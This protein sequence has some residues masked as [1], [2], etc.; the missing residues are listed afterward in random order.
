LLEDGMGASGITDGA[1][2]N[3]IGVD[4]GLMP[5]MDNGGPTRTKALMCGSVAI[6]SG[7][8]A[9]AAN[10]QRDLPV[11]GGQRDMG[12][13]ELQI[14]CDELCE[15]FSVDV[16]WGCVAMDNGWATITAINGATEPLYIEWSTGET[17]LGITDLLDGEYWVIVKDANG[18]TVKIDFTIDCSTV[19][20]DALDGALGANL[21]VF[22]V[23]ANNV[24][25]VEVLAA[26]DGVIGFYV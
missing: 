3:R 13:F 20:I 11:F 23:P 21:R 22:P 5:L 7:D 16:D 24:L 15:G 26:H 6:N 25:N 18:C 9:L 1:D 2:G 14:D 12:A 4:P 17:G 19:G 10:D 8:T